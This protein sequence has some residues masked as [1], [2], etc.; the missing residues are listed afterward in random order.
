MKLRIADREYDVNPAGD[1]VSVD[2]ET[3]ALRIVKRDS[4]LTVYVNE[5]PYAIQLPEA[6]PEDGPVTLLVDAKHYEV[7]AR[8]RAAAAP[9]PKPTKKTKSAATGAVLSQMT[10][11]VIRVDIK[12]GDTV[13]EGDILLVIEAM[14]MENEISAPM[15]GTVKEVSVAAGARVSEGDPLA[16]IEPTGA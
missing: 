4:I 5:K 1:T 2:G 13:S 9:K 6:F 12:V 8:G 3:Y 11:R 7:E 16:V 14:K 15:S 10:G